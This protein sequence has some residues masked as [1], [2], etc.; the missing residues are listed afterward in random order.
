MVIFGRHVERVIGLDG[1]RAVETW[2][3]DHGG[4]LIFA[5]GQAW[6]PSDKVATDLE[7]IAW[8]DGA[9]RGVRLEVTPQA[10]SVPAFRLLREVAAVE[11]FP[12]VIAFPATGAPKTLATTFSVAADQSPAVVYRRY[13]DGQTLSLGVG[14]LWRWVFNP[15]ADY[16]NNAYDRFWDQLALWLLAN[17][18]VTP[19]EG[20]SLR[21][22]T[23]NLPLGETIRLRFGVHGVVPPASAPDIAL[24]KDDTPVTKLA[25][26][27]TDNPMIYHAEFVPRDTGRYKAVVT[28]PDG[29]E[30]TT[31]FIVFREDLE[32]IETAMDRAYLE[33]LATASGGKMLDPTEIA[34]VLDGLLRDVSQQAP[35]TRIV[36][37]WDRA[38]VFLILCF[39][40]ASEWYARR[41][42]GL[43]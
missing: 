20:Y 32:T 19:I 28:A 42:W 14:N 39:L 7:P 37:L 13:G 40:L 11:E 36:P 2:V 35:L 17:G 18:G 22:D 3:K 25:L 34:G 43:T 5:R 23:S 41:R 27:T 29:K 31:H 1:I 16:D 9:A 10:G 38:W 8:S 21:A 33:Q 30:R 15:K 26:T 24:Y 4:V 12:E 6:P